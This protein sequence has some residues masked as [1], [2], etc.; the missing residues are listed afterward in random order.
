MRKY[1]LRLFVAIMLIIFQI[2]PVFAQVYTTDKTEGFGNCV[3]VTGSPDMYPIEFYDTDKKAYC[4]IIPD[5]LEIISE[6]SGIDFVYINGN[7]ADKNTMGNN[8]Q[9]EIVSSSAQDS[10]LPYYK[11][12]LELVSFEKDGKEVKS[13]F[14]FTSLA[15]DVM[16]SKIKAAASE[17]SAG[18]KNGI[19][20]SYAE[21]N[22][23]INYIWIA[24]AL[25]VCLLLVI[26]VRCDDIRRFYAAMIYTLKRDDIP[27]LSA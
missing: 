27:S 25:G 22:T 26:A 12:Y 2:Q 10:T 8:L 5:M 20:L 18:V 14:I 6:R 19:Y 1:M 4:G 16:I 15:D 23:R 21:E 7:K 13:G 11:D 24:I 3:Y 9:V 17:I